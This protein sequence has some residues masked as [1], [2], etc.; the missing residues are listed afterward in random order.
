MHRPHLQI[1][2]KQ[3]HFVPAVPIAIGSVWDK[4]YRYGFNSMEKDNEINVNGGSCDFG[5]RIYDGRMGRWL[6]IDVFASMYVPSASRFFLIANLLPITS[7]FTI[8]TPSGEE[9]TG[10]LNISYFSD[11]ADLTTL[12]GTDNIPD[13]FVILNST[14][15]ATILNTAQVLVPMVNITKPAITGDQFNVT[16]TP[17]NIGFLGDRFHIIIW[18]SI[19]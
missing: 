5:A 10:T 14:T 18:F 11:L 19:L 8:P 16:I 12:T 2:I 4:G 3:S 7:K 15:G 1:P 9:R 6:T 17:N 13:Q